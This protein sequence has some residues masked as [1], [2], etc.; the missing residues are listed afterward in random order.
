M[1]P[2]KLLTDIQV[3]FKKYDIQV[4]MVVIPTN[5]EFMLFSYNISPQHLH[6]FGSLLV[7]HI[8]AEKPHLNS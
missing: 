3:L 8:P 5:D 2:S 4:G 1:D 6:L 7:K